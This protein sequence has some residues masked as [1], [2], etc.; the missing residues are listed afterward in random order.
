MEFPV[1]L[2][3]GS[4]KLPLHLIFETLAFIIGYRV[5]AY[6][7]NPN[8][9]VISGFQRINIIIGAALGALIGSRLLG[10]LEQPYKWL[11]SD[12]FWMYLYTNKTIVGGLIGGWI[13]VELFKKVLKIKQSSGDLFTLPLIIAIFIGRIGCFSMGI[14]EETYGVESALPWAMDLG[15]GILRH[16]VSLYEMLF[17][18]VLGI[19]IYRLQQYKRFESGLLFKLFMINYMTYRFL[20]DFIKPVFTYEWIPLSS[21]QIACLLVLAYYSK[22]IISLITRPQELFHDPN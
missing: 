13:G 16:P 20:Q 3:I 14:Y 4:F 8:R 10:A 18:I 1:E 7:R 19:V 21:I 22:T 6:L 17:L 11:A 5:Y 12:H 9:D 15:D 2:T